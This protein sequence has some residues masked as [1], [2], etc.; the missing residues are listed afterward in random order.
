MIR[1]NLLLVKQAKKRGAGQ[2]Q[3]V[4][5]AL[6]LVVLVIGLYTA[7]DGELKKIDALKVE[8]DE[9]RQELARMEEL[10][11]DINT[12]QAKRTDLQ[13]KL[14]VIELLKKGKTG[15]VRILD[16]LSTVIPKK[17]WLTSLTEQG[18]QLRMS[19]MATDNKE[20]AV[21]MKNLENSRF[22]SN[23]TLITITQQG[24]K[25]GT[26]IPVMG[27]QINCNYSVPQS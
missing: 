9:I 18:N 7:Y 13:K 24:A 19:G 6:V 16:E 23:V 10:I 14:D 27:F 12:F 22:F 8:Q 4:L 3:L 26:A 11:G 15:P 5:F 17:V 21:F 20:I 2:K 25:A 1:I